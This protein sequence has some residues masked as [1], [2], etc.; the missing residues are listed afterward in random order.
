LLNR[1][2]RSWPE[3]Y[4]APGADLVVGRRIPAVLDALEMCDRMALCESQKIQR[5]VS[6]RNKL[7]NV[8][9]AWIQTQRMGL[10]AECAKK[11]RAR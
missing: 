4:P 1:N 8:F 5:R 3:G 11:K 7:K 2:G 10:A 6:N 9:G